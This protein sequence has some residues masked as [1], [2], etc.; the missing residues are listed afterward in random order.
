[1]YNTP[2][3]GQVESEDF[4]YHFERFGGK[5]THSTMSRLS[6]L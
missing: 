4:K 3:R 1:M 6:E 2:G 5:P